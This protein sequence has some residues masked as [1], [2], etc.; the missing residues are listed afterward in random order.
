MSGG[1]PEVQGCTDPDAD[2]YNPSATVDDGTCE[3]NDSG[4]R[5]RCPPWSPGLPCSPHQDGP[6]MTQAECEDATGCESAEPSVFT[7]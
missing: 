5:W 7:D 4:M 6:Y 1:G 2:N 3:Y